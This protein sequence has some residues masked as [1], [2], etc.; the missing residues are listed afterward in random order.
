MA[1][2]NTNSGGGGGAVNSVT[3]SVPLVSSGGANPN[4]S[5]TEPTADQIWFTSSATGHLAGSNNLI[6]DSTNL[7]F[8]AGNLGIGANGT[9][10]EVNDNTQQ[11]LGVTDGEFVIRASVTADRFFQ[12][13]TATGNPIYQL[14]DIDGAGNGTVLIL[15]DITA[16]KQALI[17]GDLGGVVG[18]GFKADFKNGWVGIGDLDG[19]DTL[20][21]IRVFVTG[22]TIEFTNATA[23]SLRFDGGLNTYSIGD[24]DGQN[25]NTWIKIDDT[26]KVITFEADSSSTT[27][28]EIPRKRRV[29]LSSAQILALNSTPVQL[30]NAPGAG[31]VNVVTQVICQYIYGTTT[32]TAPG[33]LNVSMS[34]NNVVQF[35]GLITNVT[36]I[37]KEAVPGTVT[38]TGNAALEATMTVADPTV[39]DGTLVFDIWYYS[40]TL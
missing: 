4:I 6:W 38:L 16:T 29:S 22:D 23:N 36:S 3:A 24:N 26:A 19:V 40:L 11:I 9:Y 21:G 34:G 35:G 14:G 15:N 39:G 1:R 20:T 17:K 7:V 28:H 27:S 30:V 5:I 32:Y 10:F 2:T 25:N 37:I 31:K 33:N 13:S 8:K 12:V 18:A